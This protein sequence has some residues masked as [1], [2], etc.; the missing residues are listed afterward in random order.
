MSNCINWKSFVMI[1]ALY[2]DYF[3]MDGARTVSTGLVLKGK[4]AKGFLAEKSGV[5]E[6]LNHF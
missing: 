2:I 1:S 4:G 3:S 5:A 6:Q